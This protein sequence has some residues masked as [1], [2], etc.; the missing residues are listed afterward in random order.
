MQ[1]KSLE[2]LTASEARSRAYLTRQ[3]WGRQRRFCLRCRSQKIYRL[4]DKRYRCARCR[5][6][7][8]EFSGRWVGQLNLGAR[9]WLWLVKLFEL[10]IA[11]RRI[12]DEIGIS[13]PTALKAVHLIR[14]AIARQSG[15]AKAAPSA[16]CEIH[17][18]RGGAGARQAP[19]EAPLFGVAERA[20]RV[21][22]CALAD[23]RVDDLLER[24]IPWVRRGSIL[25]FERYKNCDVVLAFARPSALHGKAG[26]AEKIAVD[27]PEGFWG[28]AAKRLFQPRAVSRASFPLYL[29]E[30]EFRYNHRDRQLFELLVD[31]A[32]GWVPNLL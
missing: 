24:A 29:K 26:A 23:V 10:E 7:F 17:F 1:L 30:L 31:H 20:G 8:Q 4:A 16:A 14:C 18:H 15:A 12:A 25:C 13:Y 5:Y 2:S 19:A 28:Y 11:P 6:T 32:T 9:D 21:S 3:A 22:I 27:R